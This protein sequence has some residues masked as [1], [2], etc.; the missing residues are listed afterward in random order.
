MRWQVVMKNHQTH[1]E[2]VVSSHLLKIFAENAVIN[3]QVQFS[4]QNF[5]SFRKERC[6]REG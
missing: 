6:P 5:L 3:R 1:E 4:G 2:V